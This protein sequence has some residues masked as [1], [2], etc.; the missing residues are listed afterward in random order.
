MQKYLAH[1]SEHLAHDQAHGNA[2]REVSCTLA[3]ILAMTTTKITDGTE[4]ENKYKFGISSSKGFHSL[5]NFS[6]DYLCEV[7]AGRES[8]FVCSVNLFNGQNL[9]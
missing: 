5:S 1:D 6:I 3:Y 4:E 7:R 8:G 2:G 9:G